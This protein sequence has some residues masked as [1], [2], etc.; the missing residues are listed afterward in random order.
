MILCLLIIPL[1][2]RSQITLRDAVSRALDGNQGL[3]SASLTAE[4]RHDAAASAFGRLLPQIDAELLYT[5][6]DRDLVL[7]LDP[8][9]SAMIGLQTG[10]KVDLANLSSIVTNGRPL[11]AQERAAVAASA[12]SALDAALPH[13]QET[14]KE[15]T[16]PQ[17]IISLRQPLFTGGKILAGIRGARDAADAADARTREQRNTVI[18]DVS[19]R[20]IDALLAA[21]AVRVR[22][23]VL[24]AVRAHRH[25]AE[26]LQEEGVIPKHD[27][28]RADVALADAERNLFEAE[29]TADMAATALRSAIGMEASAS[30]QLADSLQY[31]APAIDLGEALR[32][33]HD[34]NP[35]LLAM[36]A[37]ARALEEKSSAAKADWFPT[38]FGYGM[39]NLFDHY[40]VDGLEPKWAVGVGAQFTVFDGMRRSRAVAETRADAAS[41]EAAT[42]EADRKI[43]LAVRGTHLAL[44][45][46][47]ERYTRLDASVALAEEQCRLTSRRYETGLGT[48]L[49]TLDALAHLEGLRLQRLSALRDMY[50]A[51]LALCQTQGDA[52]RFLA[53]WPE[54]AGR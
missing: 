18:A 29:Q 24:A 22:T 50:A 46:A 23:E 6:M 54:N 9:R 44:R 40:M 5:H 13:F 28:L 4:A 2:A 51:E 1:Q 31:R 36:R 37:A 26:R 16:F 45:L 49:E 12:G 3:R 52:A 42:A 7:D 47:S 17:G 19:N 33:A 15:R 38:I 32:A 39:L 41:M 21:S 27:R 35:T 43:A 30:V 25:Q 11:T 10:T 53:C 14:V 48:S 20:Y 8:I 34:G